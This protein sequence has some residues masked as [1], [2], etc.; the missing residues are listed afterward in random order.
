MQGLDPVDFDDLLSQT[1]W[2]R[3]L[4]RSLIHWIGVNH[5]DEVL[6]AGCGTG[7]FVLQLAQR[8]KW[9]TG[10]DPSSE[11]VERAKL[12]AQDL[13]VENINFAVGDVHQLAFPKARF[14]LVV[15]LN[16]LFAFEDAERAL[17]ELVRVCRPQGQIVLLNPGPNMNPWAVQS[18]S[19][20]H[21]LRD[22][23]RD[24]LLSFA[25][26]AAR[27]PQFDEQAMASMAESAGAKVADAVVLLEG[28]AVVTQL[29][30][31]VS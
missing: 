16:Q 21:N 22:F 8:A 10:L 4:Q 9:V 29:L 6:E 5:T 20:V 23:E 27:H 1:E 12:N 7:R 3:S 28:L 14:D 17:S 15:A 25:T 13:S 2:N 18:F 31:E 19:E 11:M 30:P 24:S 26:A